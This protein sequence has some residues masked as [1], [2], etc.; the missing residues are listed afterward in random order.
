MPRQPVIGRRY[1]KTVRGITYLR[2]I[3]E[4]GEITVARITPYKNRNKANTLSS[5]N[6]GHTH[7]P[8]LSKLIIAKPDVMPNLL[9]LPGTHKVYVAE[10]DRA[11]KV[12]LKIGKGMW[13]M[14]Y[15]DKLEEYQAKVA[16][17][18]E[19]GLKWDS[20]KIAEFFAH[21]TDKHR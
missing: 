7:M 16:E 15:P 6:L 14:V 18:L 10:N 2:E 1:E 21:K 8:R 4:N 19:K 12:S 9:K 17:D 20:A 5:P 13:I 3:T 11:E